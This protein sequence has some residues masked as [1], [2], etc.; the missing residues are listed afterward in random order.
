MQPHDFRTVVDQLIDLGDRIGGID[1]IDRHLRFRMREDIQDVAGF[2][3]LAQLHDRDAVT[4][5]LDNRHFVR[6]QDDRDAQ[7][8]IDFL[9]QHENAG[10]RLRIQ[11]AGRFVA[12]QHFWIV[13]QRPRDCDPLLLSAGQL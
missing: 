3:D 8:L 6:D 13:G 2:D 12:Q 4:D 11:R 5:F 1:E 7:L 10:G 9:Q